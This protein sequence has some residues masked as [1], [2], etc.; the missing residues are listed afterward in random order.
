MGLSSSVTYFFFVKNRKDGPNP[1]TTA[2][3]YGRDARW[4]KGAIHHAITH[5]LRESPRIYVYRENRGR[6]EGYHAVNTLR[7]RAIVWGG[8]YVRGLGVIRLDSRYRLKAMVCE[9]LGWWHGAQTEACRGAGG[10]AWGTLGWH[11]GQTNYQRVRPCT[12]D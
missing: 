6:I 11:P 12:R 8:Y 2:T 5:T 10:P 1:L 4:H 7:S 3:R 9:W